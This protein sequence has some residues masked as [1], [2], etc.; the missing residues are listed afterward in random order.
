M[1][2]RIIRNDITTMAVDAIVNAANRSLLGGGGVDGAI[3]AAAGPELL[4]ECRTLG[5][6]EVGQAKITGAY[7]LPCRYVIHTVGPRWRGGLMG[8]KRQLASCYRSALELA[9]D[10]GCET[11]AFPLISSGAYGYPKGKAMQVAVDAISAFLLE[12][13]MTVYLVLYGPDSLEIGHRLFTEIQEYIDNHYVEQHPTHENR[14]REREEV[15]ESLPMSA[16][17]E[18]APSPKTDGS[19]AAARE[20]WAPQQSDRNAEA[21][22]LDGDFMA[23]PLESSQAV[24]PPPRPTLAARPPKA[25]AGASYDATAALD[26]L[27]FDLDES[28]Q[29]MLL[30]KIDESGMTDA[31]CYKKANIDRK[32]FSKIRKDS[33]YK[34]SKATAIAFAIALEL[35]LRETESL[36]RKAGFALSRSSKF[37]VIIQY[38]IEHRSYNIFEINEVLFHYDQSLLG[39]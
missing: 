3:H 19:T 15:W 27:F 4:A 25:A 29:Q 9:R 6:C 36:L 21:P 32:L 17:W 7:R 24:P 11:V 5:G 1:P 10:K 34:P 30:R 14:R 20:D 8:E 16:M 12:N 31:Q 39:G 28:F 35:D 13:D 2:F 26:D 33:S 18:D 22:E 37:D 38:F 23:K